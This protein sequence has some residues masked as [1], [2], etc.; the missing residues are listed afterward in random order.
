MQVPD[1][2]RLIFY[3]LTTDLQNPKERNEIEYLRSVGRVVLV[4]SQRASERISGIR[5]LTLAPWS[6]RQI[7]ADVLWLKVCFLLSRI[8]N[9]STDREFP[10]RN[11]YSANRFVRAIVNQFWKLKRLTWVNRLLPTFDWLYF[12][13]FRILAFLTGKKLR[14]RSYRVVVHD[15][16]ALRLSGFSGFIA[17]ARRS[18]I[19]TLAN[20]KSWDNPFYSQLTS[21]ADS[22][23]VWSRSMWTDLQSAHALR[24]RPIHVWGARPFYN[25]AQALARAN[26]S[27]RPEST[28]EYVIGYAAAFC[29]TLMLQYELAVLGRIA[30][31]LLKRLPNARILVRPY[32]TLPLSEYEPLTRYRNI[33]V[34]EIDGELIDRYS[35]G[36]ELIRFG[37][38]EERIDYLSRC[39]CFLSMATSFT[40]EAAMFGAPIVHFYLP[41]EKCTDLSERKFFE[42]IAISDHLRV[43][44]IQELLTVDNYN[45]LVEQLAAVCRGESV[46]ARQR[47]Q[48]S[49][50][51]LGIPEDA[52]AW[53]RTAS[54]LVKDIRE[55]ACH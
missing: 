13:P 7:A 23:L 42:R 12:A 51:R 2:S 15:A 5:N 22:F 20:V 32:P 44:F 18:G 4:S 54:S 27:R 52:A 9:S 21:G 38:D 46:M 14:A 39:H 35:D 25:F 17:V 24:D 6:S 30:N 31:H 40:I 8:A 11:V 47:G 10:V 43:Y 45:D 29:E 34:K 36:R 3:F 49:I 19:Q 53:H 33:Q 1:D 50:R 37:S 28:G 55:E 26:G 16:L 41:P 48:A